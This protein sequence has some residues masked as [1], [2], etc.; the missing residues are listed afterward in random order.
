M[1]RCE[2]VAREL[3]FERAPK[4]GPVVVLGKAA[5]WKQRVGIGERPAPAIEADDAL[6]IGDRFALDRL[7]ILGRLAQ[8]PEARSAA[9]PLAL[10]RHSPNNRANGTQIPACWDCP[11]CGTALESRVNTEPERR[12]HE[13]R[14]AALSAACPAR[15]PTCGGRGQ[16][17]RRFP[18][19]T[20][21]RNC[22]KHI[23]DL[24]QCSGENLIIDLSATASYT[25]TFSGTSTINGVLIVHPDGSANFHDVEVFTGTVN[26]V[27]GTVTF[28]LNGSNDS[29]LT[30]HATATIV[31]AT[32]G[33]A[34]LH[35]VLHEIGTVVI[36]S[37]P[38]G[39]YTGKIH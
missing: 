29:A 30:V 11:I 32:G 20:G 21:E 13:P 6:K 26:G 7:A 34:G 8:P 3:Q 10:G 25:G 1:L 17:C 35:G 15:R 19:D 2:V 9:P 4:V 36:P 33:L 22:R 18:A 38:V 37:G 31:D 14:E 16:W 5:E 12:H 27:P 24:Q 23:G 28:N 39:T